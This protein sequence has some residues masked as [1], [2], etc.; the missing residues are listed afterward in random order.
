MDKLSSIIGRAKDWVESNIDNSQ[1]ISSSLFEKMVQAKIYENSKDKRA[2]L[3]VYGESQIGKSYLM[4]R[5][6]KHRE[7][8]FI[9]LVNGQSGFSRHI[10]DGRYVD[11]LN[12]IN[13]SGGRES[14]GVVTRFTSSTSH[15]KS[16][17]PIKVTFL[18]Q[19]DLAMII[20][21]T[22]SMDFD[23]E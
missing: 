13:P 6:F 8:F 9:R 20:A 19:I 7:R 16:E 15:Q 4:S 5:L 1:V 21:D 22:Y 17:A 10:V 18:R 14:S 3:A 23:K 12:S 2:T 11:F